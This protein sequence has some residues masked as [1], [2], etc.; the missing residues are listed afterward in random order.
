MHKHLLENEN[1]FIEDLIKLQ[2]DPSYKEKL[3]A[4]I[5]KEIMGEPFI[6]PG[7]GPCCTCQ[8]C[9]HDFD[10]CKCSYCDCIEDAW[11]VREKIH[12]LNFLMHIDDVCVEVF[13]DWRYSSHWEPVGESYMFGDRDERIRCD[14]EA[15]CLASLQ[16]V[17]HRKRLVK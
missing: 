11:E 1:I 2:N 14:A 8:T 6:V 10:N 7:H 3:N 16:A 15:I 9:G 13:S 12:E 5:A 17:R 4:A